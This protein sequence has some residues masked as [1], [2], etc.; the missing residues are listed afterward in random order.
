MDMEA[1]KKIEELE[2]ELAELQAD[3]AV[4]EIRLTDTENELALAVGQI[5]IM[6]SDC[7]YDSP[8]LN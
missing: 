1:V 4:L 7:T 2:A 6:K 3:N 5:I 8:I